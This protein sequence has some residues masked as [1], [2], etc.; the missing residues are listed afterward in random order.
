MTD[1]IYP[2]I[3][4]DQNGK[5]VA[6][7]YCKIFPNTQLTEDNGMVQMLSINRQKLMLLSAGRQF[8]PNASISFLIANMDE[9]ETVRLFNELSEGGIVLMPLASYPFSSK[10]GWVRDKFGITWQLYTGEKGDTDQ[11]FVPTLM[12]INQ[13][14]GRAK[15]AVAFYTQLFPN[16]KTEGIMAYEDEEDIKGNVKHAQFSINGYTLA[17]MDSSHAHPFNFDEGISLVVLTKDQKET[18]FYWNKLSTDGGEE[19]MCGWLKDKF[20]LSWQIVPEQLLSLLQEDGGKK[21]SKVM[22][23]L[24]QMRK[25]EI[26]KLTAV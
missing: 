14:N 17:C 8:K 25:I 26:S 6:D 22:D 21:A 20:G 9:Q 4:L 3:W 10:Y 7:Y 5:E 2:C 16:S 11:Y 12:Y 24:M 19:S 15:E 18:D 13:Q 1:T 23:A